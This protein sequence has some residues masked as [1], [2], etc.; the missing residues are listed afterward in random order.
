MS[1][2]PNVRIAMAYDGLGNAVVEVDH[3]A[4]ATTLE[5]VEAPEPHPLIRWRLFVAGWCEGSAPVGLAAV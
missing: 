4:E 1:D 5:L 3:D 2:C